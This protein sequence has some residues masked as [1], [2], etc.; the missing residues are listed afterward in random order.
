MSRCDALEA[1]LKQSQAD[2]DRLLAAAVDHR[3]Y[4]GK[5]G[6]EANREHRSGPTRVETH[7][8]DQSPLRGKDQEVENKFRLALRLGY[9]AHSSFELRHSCVLGY[10]V[11]RHFAPSVRLVQFRLPPGEIK[12]DKSFV[13]CVAARAILLEAVQSRSGVRPTATLNG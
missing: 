13:G 12:T 8:D 9:R 6:L 7:D 5:P 3:T 2:G 1:Q 11:I 10:F 4:G